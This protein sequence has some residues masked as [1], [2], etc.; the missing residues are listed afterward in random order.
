MQTK[1]INNAKKE[2]ANL[3]LLLKYG[4][5]KKVCNNFISYK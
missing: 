3:Y 4:G 5:S 1:D 2:L